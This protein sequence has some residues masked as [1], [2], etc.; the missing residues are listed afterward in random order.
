[1]EALSGVPRIPLRKFE[2]DTDKIKRNLLEKGV[3]PTPKVIHTLRKKEIQKHNRKLNKTQTD[4]APPPP[5]HLTEESH[6]KTLK[7]EYMDFNKEVNSKMGVPTVGNPWERLDSLRL[8]EL[9]GATTE[10]AGEKLRREE[11]RE[12]GRVF[13]A[14]KRDELRWVLEDDLEI[15]EEVLNGEKKV[16]DPLKRRRGEVEVIQFLVDRL[17]STKLAIKD[18]KLSRIMKQSG[19]A[20]T[21]PQ[22]LR[23]VDGLGAKRCWQTAMSVVEWVYED[24]ERGRNKSRFAYTKLMAVLGKARK[25]DDALSVFN[26]MRGNRHIYPDMAAYHSIAVTLGQAGRLKELLNIMECMRKK[27]S[28]LKN[29][30][31][32]NWDPVLEPDVVVYNAVL[33]ACV[34]SQQ[35]KAVSW[36]FIQL[37]KSGLKPNGATYGLAM[38]VMLQSGKYDLVHEYF[39][40][41]RKSGEAPKALTY[42][43]LVKALWCEGKVNEAVEAVRDMEQRGVVGASS[44]YYELACCLCSVGRWEDAMLEVDKMKKLSNTRPLAVTFTGMI[45]SSMRSGHIDDCISIFETMKNH[46]SP[47]IGTINTMLKVYGRN[48]MFSK[49]KELFEEIKKANSD[50]CP[51][52][53]GHKTLLVPDEFT[54]SSMLEAS[55]SALQWEYFEFVYKEMVISG[56]QLDQTKHASL[57][58]KA[59]R[60]GK[61]HLLENAF[62]AILEAE[63]IPNSLYWTEMVLQNVA[64]EDYMKAVTLINAMALAPFK[65]SEEQWKELFEKYEEKIGQ[66]NLEKLLDYL[67][68]GDVKSEP[69]VV[70]LSRALRHLCDSGIS[71]NFSSSIDCGSENVNKSSLDD[72][73][74]M[75][76]GEDSDSDEDPPSFS[77]DLTS[78]EVDLDNDRESNLLTSTTGLTTDE[79]LNGE[80]SDPL[81]GSY[82]TTDITESLVDV[83]ESELEKLLNGVHHSD[84]SDLPSAYEVLEAWKESRRKDGVL[85][86][87]RL[88][89][90]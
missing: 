77:I 86:S 36:V 88:G 87:S 16:W 35:W 56:Y 70:N 62:N 75:T 4:Q 43:V 10:Y 49:A 64:Q 55:A 15:S 12:L 61:W 8:R 67:D 31:F 40:K 46:C 20:F 85:F 6:F 21:E 66:N 47:N 7:R 26:L 28:K 24:K 72:N 71:G 82:S 53:D 81:H 79:A 19:L 27:P 38:E 42:K 37:R 34:P 50:S 74:G 11:L 58:L 83:D 39:R 30:Q 1:M 32:K 23:I 9:A 90:K 22:L 51:S 63:D 44:V 89:Q 69:T 78:M 29:I 41:M 17:S 60:N 2:P 57:L 3:Q 18:W 68:N 54:Y 48:D 14:R 76:F 25:P 65:I 52:L 73:V 84:K 13:E 80:S 5:L 33:N 45:M 59:S